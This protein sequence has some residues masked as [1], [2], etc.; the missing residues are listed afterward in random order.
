MAPEQA[1]CDEVDRRSDVFAAGVILWELLH[2]RRY[3]DSLGDVQILKRMTFGDLP[4]ID[5]SLPE[6][7]RAVLARALATKPEERY[8]TA[9]EMRAE[10]VKL[11]SSTLSRKEIGAAVAEAAAGYRDALKAVVDAHLMSA[12]G[13]GGLPG[14]DPAA[15]STR[16]PAAEPAAIEEP[17]SAP[18]SSGPTTA[19]PP[20]L[21]AVTAA[22]PSP[23]STPAPALPFRAFTETGGA[24]AL[25]LPPRPKPRKRSGLPWGIAAVALVAA[26]VGVGI[27]VTR[28]REQPAAATV[29]AD[30]PAA[31][32]AEQ[33]ALVA[34]E[35][36]VSPPGARAYLDE[37]ALP[38]LPFSAKLERDGKAHAIRVEADGYLSEARIVVFDRDVKL[39]VA[40]RAEPPELKASAS[41]A[42]TARASSR[43]RA[44]SSA[45]VP[46]APKSTSVADSKYPW[47]KKK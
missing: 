1:L 19:P 40:L 16:A 39:T 38:Q 44:P 18:V 10:L 2:G 12:R 42:P 4:K 3:W 46:P 26:A 23:L 9:R 35:L 45:P 11:K 47:G 32:A 7:V 6:P 8:P 37:M 36:E 30:A 27:F 5:D 21:G 43:P 24:S 25:D 41:A 20:A 29:N 15:V 31:G 34:F 28:D 33:G 14:V 13:T 22:A 17:V